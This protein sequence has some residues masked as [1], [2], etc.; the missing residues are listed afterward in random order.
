MTTL[1]GSINNILLNIDYFQWYE[2]IS[3]LDIF[4]RHFSDVI[5]SDE[6][7]FH[8]IIPTYTTMGGSEPYLDIMCKKSSHCLVDR[9]LYEKA[10]YLEVSFKPKEESKKWGEYGWI[11]VSFK[12]LKPKSASI[13][14]QGSDKLVYK[15]RS[16]LK[17]NFSYKDKNIENTYKSLW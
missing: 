15:L 17:K 3:V 11:Q 14:I 1:R 2:I 8:N 7:I 12:G 16:Y 13:Y 10:V 6:V 4:L 5:Y 9:K